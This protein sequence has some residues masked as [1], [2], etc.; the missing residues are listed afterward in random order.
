MTETPSVNL[1]VAMGQD[2]AIGIDGNLIWNLPG[3]LKRFKSLTLGHPVIMGRKTWESLPKRP[4][5]GRRNIILS[6]SKDFT[7]EGAEIANSLE[8]AFKM[9]SGEQP[10]IIGGAEIYNAFIPYTSRLYLTLV[11]DVCKEADARLDLNLKKN[12]E[13]ISREPDLTTPEGLTFRYINF[14]KKL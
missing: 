11:D 13:E 5:P 2:G 14:K 10:F 7:A 4:L 9:T 1:I 8:E 3:D 6:R 12:W